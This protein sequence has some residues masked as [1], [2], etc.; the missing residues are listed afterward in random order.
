LARASL[1]DGYQQ[2]RA[3]QSLLPALSQL[4]PM[5]SLGFGPLALNFLAGAVH[6]FE[7]QGAAFIVFIGDHC[8]ILLK[9]CP[10][11]PATRP[12]VE[13]SP[14]I[15]DSVNIWW[16][17]KS[18]LRAITKKVGCSGF[19]YT[20]FACWRQLLLTFGSP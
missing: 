15:C 20:I 16:D 11:K 6:F 10:K 18:K 17:A 8:S 14:V 2:K 12:V 4:P 3:G 7:P 1:I 13:Q 19:A 9:F 5:R